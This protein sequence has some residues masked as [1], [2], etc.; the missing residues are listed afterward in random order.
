MTRAARRRGTAA[1]SRSR[2]GITIRSARES[3]ASRAFGRLMGV[4]RIFSVCLLVIAMAGAARADRQEWRLSGAATGVVGSM[5][6]SGGSSSPLAA[7]GRVRGAYGLTSLI[8]IGGNIGLVG[9][10]AI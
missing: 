2:L 10:A 7:G 1:I 8:E 3:S 5:E 4:G 6:T 9:A